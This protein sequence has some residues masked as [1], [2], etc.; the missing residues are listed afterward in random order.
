LEWT[1]VGLIPAGALRKVKA[2][3]D[4]ASPGRVW[5]PEDVDD[6]HRA[7]L[8][9]ASARADSA[10]Q[11]FPGEFVAMLGGVVITHAPTMSEVCDTAPRLAG[12]NSKWVLYV[13]PRGVVPRAR[14]APGEI[15]DQYK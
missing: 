6:E 2:M 8:D 10:R 11:Q 7:L 1:I 12:R 14:K 3:A 5:I 4:V 15:A 13:P 9:E